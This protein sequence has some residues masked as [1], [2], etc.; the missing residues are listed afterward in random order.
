MLF[1]SVEDKNVNPEK[2]VN[3]FQFRLDFFLCYIQFDEVLNSVS[4]LLI[5]EFITNYIEV[6]KQEIGSKKKKTFD[7]KLNI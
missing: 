2:L 4:I 1:K 6:I 5:E 3:E 7:L